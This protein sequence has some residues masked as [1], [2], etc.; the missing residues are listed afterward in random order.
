MHSSHSLH[1]AITVVLSQC[2]ANP[3]HK[4]LYHTSSRYASHPSEK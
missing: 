4:G 1:Y 3:G 2:F